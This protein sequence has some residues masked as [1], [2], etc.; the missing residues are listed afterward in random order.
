MRSERAFPRRA[1]SKVNY[2]YAWDHSR[3]MT[4][5]T[6]S[7]SE[8]LRREMRSHPEVNWSE[9]ARRAIK[10]ELERLHIYDRLFTSSAL[11]ESDAV[12]LG[13]E[14]RRGAA[15]RRRRM[16]PSPEHSAETG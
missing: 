15:H 5:M 14:V 2:T 16:T 11:T 8:E 1:G 4:K 12:A 10:R 3:H 6:L 9:V 13:R 7:L